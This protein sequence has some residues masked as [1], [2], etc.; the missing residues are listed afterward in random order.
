[1]R[2]AAVILAGL[3]ALPVEAQ[4]AQSLADMRQDLA[5]LNTE[6]RKLKT[7]LNTT[8]AP[9]AVPGGGSTLDRVSAIEA[10][11]SRLTGKV[12]ELEHRIDRV[13]TDGTNRIGDLA[14]RLCELEPGCDVSAIGKTAPLGGDAPA[15][16]GGGAAPQPP[17]T[18]TGALPPANNSGPQLA[19]AEEAD[20]QAASNALA[21]GDFENAASLFATFRQTYPGSPMEPQVLFG[22]GQALEALGDTREAARAYLALFSGYPDS[23]VAP[24]GLARLGISLGALGKVAEACV[25]LADVEGRYPGAAAVEDART[26][27]A[28]LNCS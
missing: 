17:A 3:L 19:V 9:G 11:L 27:M 5:V 10:E 16:T 15:T 21:E 28:S 1:M 26:A 4:D 14:F 22:H 12:E 2:F 13:V 20:Y 6:L 23:D 18:D 24:D 8:G 7:E 25:T